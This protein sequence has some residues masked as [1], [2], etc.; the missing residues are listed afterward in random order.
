MITFN[1]G[2]SNA[3]KEALH[4]FSNSSEQIFEI[5]GN[6][7][8]GK[9]V[10]INEILTQIQNK[11]KIPMERIAPMAYTGA[12]SIV[13]RL[14]GLVNA[15]TI[16]SWLYEA[17]EVPMTR[18]DGS[19]VMDTYLNVPVMTL[20]FVPRQLK[21][22]LDIII[23]DEGG[24]VPLSMKNELLK[25]GAKILVAGD[26]DQLPP[27]ADRPAFLTDFSKVHYLTE[28]MRQAEG[29]AIIYLS[30][31]VKQGLPIHMGLY[32]N[33]VLVIEDTEVSN[34]MLMNSPV[35]L[36]GRNNTRD[37]INNYIR[38]DIKGYKDMMPK[39]LE[40]V[41]CRE[42]NWVLECDGIN[43]TNGLTGTVVNSPDP[44]G[45]DGKEFRI[46]FIPDMLPH[47]VFR[48]VPVSYRY[49]CADRNT[50]D[51][52]KQ[53]GMVSG[54][55]FEYGYAQTVHLAQGSQWPQGIYYEEYLNREINNRVHYTA[56]TRFSNRCIYVKQK[57]KYY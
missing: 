34:E 12:A 22:K 26:I 9:S 1:Q 21:G 40:K 31:R 23:I 49:L 42:N 54:N 35:V 16:H 14:K 10:V 41:I 48:N 55:L 53:S 6:P 18:E 15:K 39:Y 51:L 57:R 43:L 24:T 11:Y 32:G 29:S 44:S 52:L 28:I 30:Q 33:D 5:S 17:I 45:F 8:T 2:Q 13:M 20:K 19:I 47:A 36:C 25:T 37:N 27:V 4:W 3:I 56:L 50:K 46:D 38:Q 7:G